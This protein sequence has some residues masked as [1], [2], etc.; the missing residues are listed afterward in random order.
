MNT[1]LE[2]LL[3]ADRLSNPNYLQ[4]AVPTVLHCTQPSPE[5]SKVGARGLYL[6]SMG[7]KR[8]K[9]RKE[10]KHGEKGGGGYNH[11]RMCD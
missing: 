7:G 4:R 2:F 11:P 9:E 5:S 8:R 6:G 10:R 3:P 1:E